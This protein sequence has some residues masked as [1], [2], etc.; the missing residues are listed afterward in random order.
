MEQQAVI[1]F[2][3]LKGL[4]VP[5]LA[6]EL[7]MASGAEALV[8]LTVKKWR[9]RF[10][11]GRTWLCDDPKSGKT[12]TH[13][14]AEAVRSMLKERPFISCKLLAGHFRIKKASCLR[15]LYESLGMRKVNL[16]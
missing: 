6:A 12:L 9:M 8:F 1:R 14:L 5:A 15:I 7:E 11:E 10:A 13:D 4:C 2:F 3:T 16:H